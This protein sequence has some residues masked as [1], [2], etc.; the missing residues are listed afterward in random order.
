MILSIVS[1][2]ILFIFNKLKSVSNYKKFWI[3]F[4][5]NSFNKRRYGQVVRQRTANPLSPVQ[6]WVSPQYK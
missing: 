3:T 4:I 2:I 5:K 6:I 1:I